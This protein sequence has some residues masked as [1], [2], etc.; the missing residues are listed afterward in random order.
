[1]VKEEYLE[2]EEFSK[3]LPY[4]NKTHYLGYI[5]SRQQIGALPDL[6]ELLEISY[7][8]EPFESIK[9]NE[10][11]I[12][13]IK[14]TLIDL[15]AIR[16]DLSLLKDFNDITMNQLEAKI[17]AKESKPAKVTGSPTYIK[18]MT[19]N[20]YKRL[21]TPITSSDRD[22]KD[23][24]IRESVE[25]LGEYVKTQGIRNVDI[26]IP[27]DSSSSFNVDLANYIRETILI[28]KTANTISMPKN[29]SLAVNY[30]RVENYVKNI[31]LKAIA[32]P[33]NSKKIDIKNP[34]V[35]KNGKID[36]TVSPNGFKTDPPSTD[37]KT[38]AIN[39]QWRMNRNSREGSQVGDPEEIKSSI[40]ASGYEK[41]MNK[42]TKQNT[43][44][45]VFLFNDIDD[46]FTAEVMNIN[47]RLT[48]VLATSTAIKT[49]QPAALRFLVDVFNEPS[50]DNPDSVVLIVDD[51]L[52]SG[53]TTA[54][55]YSL[56]ASKLNANATIMVFV[57]L[58]IPSF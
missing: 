33:K 28:A 52:S 22:A 24:L 36:I 7:N 34:K 40:G 3:N 35:L 5:R 23:A 12:E 17:S 30:Q 50:F 27:L 53:A 15:K 54:N 42:A 18:S 14:E 58:A 56:V 9:N 25:Y 41:V 49:I 44:S 38:G 26:I 10:Q 32:D 16:R 19:E 48:S 13:E 46:A 51:N 39:W 1:M 8:E 2:L 11:I 21:K 31:I 20:L 45:Y 37:P 57:P 6:V 29:H 47:E 55:A 43:G 4:I